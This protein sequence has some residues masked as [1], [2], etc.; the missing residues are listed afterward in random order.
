MIANLNEARPGE[1][2][3]SALSRS[4][5][6]LALIALA[7]IA[8][9]PSTSALLGLWTDTRTL[10]YVHG[11]LIVA[12]SLW[13]LY[14]DRHGISAPISRPSRPAAIALVACSVLWLLCVRAGVQAGHLVLFVPIVWLTVFAAF[15]LGVARVVAFPIGFL[16][17]SMPIWNVL[18]ESLQTLTAVAVRAMAAIIGLPAYVEGHVIHIPEG[19]FVIE[20]ACSGLHLLVTG[21]AVAAYQGQLWRAPLWTR[22]RLLALMGVLGLVC[23]WLRV[24]TVVVAG[25]LTNMQHYLV[26]VDHYFLGWMLFAGVLALFIWITHYWPALPERAPEPS[27]SAR[28][29]SAVAC[30]VAAGA[31]LVVPLGARALQIFRPAADLAPVSLPQGVSG[32]SGPHAP[33]NIAWQPEFPGATQQLQGEYANDSGARATVYFV[34]YDDQHQGAELVREGNSLIGKDGPDVDDGTVVT[35]AGAQMRETRMP[36]RPGAEA[37]IWSQYDIAGRPFVN[38][39]ASQ[40]WYAVRSLLSAPRSSLLAVRVACRPDCNEARRTGERFFRVMAPALAGASDGAIA[41]H[42]T[43]P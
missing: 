39:R 4:L 42:R 1:S 2:R 43:T 17:F 29:A 11:P 13:V 33:A 24:F 18:T 41:R 5:I 25:H 21:L 35:L 8:M 37:L 16:Y 22:V 32:W 3:V 15:G 27:P 23:N 19:T 9:W 14:E 34:S 12:M 7:A 26:R 38:P 6:V 36:G 40:G 28:P 10:A 30:A 31:L 20:T